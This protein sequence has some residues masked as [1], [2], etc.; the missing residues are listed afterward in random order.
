M[1]ELLKQIIF[2]QQTYSFANTVKRD[3]DYSLVSS[4]EILI[5]SGI[6]R[7]GKS[8][9]LQQ[10]RAKQAEKDYF[11]NFDDERLINFGIADFQILYE[12]FIE[13]F[14]VQKTFY[15]DEIQN[16]PGWER[17]VRRMYD[18]GCKIFITGSNATMLSKELGTHL[19]GRYC[20][21][22]LYP[23]SFE[24]FLKLK[25][26]SPQEKDFYTTS[27]IATLIK[28]FHDY[29]KTGGFPAYASHPN[30][31]Y[32]S[33]LYESIIYKDVITRNKIEN[34]KELLETV[35][36]LAS[37]ATKR[38]SYNSLSKIV[39]I[40]HPETIKNYIGYLEDTYL[41]SQVLK[42]DY[43]LKTQMANMKKAYFVDNAI[44]NKIGF[45]ATEN[46]GQLLEN[47][48]WIELKRRGKDIYY[49]AGNVECDF[50]VRTGTKITEA[51]QVTQSIKNEKTRDREIKG[52]LEA[53]RSYQ[54]DSGYILT[55]NET[56]MLT[57]DDKEII[58]MPIWKWL[59]K[60]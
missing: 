42:F 54:L 56:D 32:L 41:L 23:F 44:I 39:G 1:K 33:S 3:I 48:V 46:Q 12:T 58:I 22:E 57:V 14:G 36:Y 19:T 47:V 2:E 55:V 7:C 16:I 31:N 40:K 24:E 53:L 17:F 52:L 27:G 11:I 45:N 20:R 35:Y 60:K 4:P 9:L 37:N 13:L 59:L 50:V 10:L 51:Y 5:I 21:L 38:F 43:S 29:L 28:Y 6:R 26:A 30:E 18:A 8:V 15:F 25:Q 34:G 49:H